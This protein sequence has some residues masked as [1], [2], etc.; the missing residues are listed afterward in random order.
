M[1]KGKKSSRY[2]EFIRKFVALLLRPTCFHGPLYSDSS[3]AA[4]LNSV[5]GTSEDRDPVNTALL[6]RSFKNQFAGSGGH[7]ILKCSELLG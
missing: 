7:Y 3:I 2:A 1:S 5:I 6:W 4:G